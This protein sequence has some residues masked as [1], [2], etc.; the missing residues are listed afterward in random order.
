MEEE[1]WTDIHKA[2]TDM[3]RLGAAVLLTAIWRWNVD[4]LH[5]EGRRART[6]AEAVTGA[7][8]GVKEAYARHKMGKF[9]LTAMS[10]TALRIV[11]KIIRHW[12]EEQNEPTQVS[13]ST[14]MQRI[15]FFDGGSRGNPGPGGSGSVFVEKSATTSAGTIVWAAVTALGCPNMN[16]NVAEFVGLH[17]LLQ[18]ASRRGW[19][20]IHV[21][22]GSAMILR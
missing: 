2:A 5:P 12:A 22:G 16:N 7:M 21:V 14:A 19:K 6:L 8:S 17:R 20:D 10:H 11:G 4:R 3:W 9:P 15:D 13:K 1:P 18:Y